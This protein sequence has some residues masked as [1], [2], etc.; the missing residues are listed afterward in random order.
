VDA[1][2]LSMS[3]LS[4]EMLTPL[5]AARAI[6]IAVATNS[7]AKVAFAAFTGRPEMARPYAM[8]ILGSGLV[9]ITVAFLAWS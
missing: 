6:A 3:R 7:A 9:G 8:A 4:G 2:T 1:V 5:L